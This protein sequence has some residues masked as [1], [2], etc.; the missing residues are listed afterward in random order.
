MSCDLTLGRL[1]PCKDQSA[2]IK[3]IYFINYDGDLKSGA[4]LGSDDEITGFASVVNL[5]KYEVRGDNNTFDEPNEVNKENGTSFWTQ[6][7]TVA[8]K[9]Q[10]I[11]D[12]KE[13]KVA[14]YGRPHIVVEDYNGNYQLAGFE[15]GCDVS[16]STASGGAM[17]DFRGYNV[18]ATGNETEPA[19]FIDP[20]IIDDTTNTVVVVGT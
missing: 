1:E 7:L 18:V 12:R 8:L 4:T 16:V 10:S 6:T 13:L 3:N 9:K 17:G 15:N 5:L 2:G 14:T 11:T 19:H 20:A